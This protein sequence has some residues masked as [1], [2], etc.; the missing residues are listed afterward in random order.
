M[1]ALEIGVPLVATPIVPPPT[2]ASDPPPQSAIATPR[3]P[4]AVAPSTRKRD[5]RGV[6]VAFAAA[7]VVLLGGLLWAIALR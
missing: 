7:A 3:S 5:G 1:A 4:D 6:L 2:T